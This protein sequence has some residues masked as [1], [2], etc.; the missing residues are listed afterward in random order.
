MP[1]TMLRGATLVSFV[2]ATMILGPGEAVAQSPDLSKVTAKLSVQAIAIIPIV[3]YKQG[4][5]CQAYAPDSDATSGGFVAWE[6]AN[7]VA[8]DVCKDKKV[9]ITNFMVGAAAATS[10]LNAKCVTRQD[11]DDKELIICKVTKH[12]DPKDKPVYYKYS[13]KG[14][15]SVDPQL[16]VRPPSTLTCKACNEY[17]QK[18]PCPEK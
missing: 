8:P 3:L 4:E 2:L 17:L 6:I 15:F 14:S 18:H 5:K 13:I 9:E 16:V 1:I 12:L 10:P 11:A 7:S